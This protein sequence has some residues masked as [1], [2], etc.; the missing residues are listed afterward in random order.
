[1]ANT[2]TVIEQKQVTLYNDEVTAVRA[3]DSQIYVSIR[4]MCQA[5]DLDPNGQNQRINRHTVLSDGKGVCK[6]H[7]PGGQQRVQMLR[8]DLVPLWLT[9]VSIKS[10][11]DDDTRKK[12]E[13]FQ[14]KAAQILWDAF[15]S[16]ELT[17]PNIEEL[18]SQ[19]TPEAQ[20]YKMLQGML[21]LARNQLLLRSRLDD[22]EQTP[23]ND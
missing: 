13:R 4:H 1:M 10:I 18:L 3:D 2:L 9:T 12:L 22:H 16:G 7:T 15:Q 8:A 17:D 11:K 5:L 19:D 6:I 23:G 20:A 21:H 14:R